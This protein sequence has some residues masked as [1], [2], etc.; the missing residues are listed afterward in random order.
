MEGPFLN[1]LTV[2][3]PEM[4]PGRPNLKSYSHIS[5]LQ[6]VGTV[7]GPFRATFRLAKKGATGKATNVALDGDNRFMGPSWVRAHGL[8]FGKVY[9]VWVCAPPKSSLSYR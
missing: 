8:I 4:D 9:I 7:P 5:A 2:L 3:G 6:P 1:F